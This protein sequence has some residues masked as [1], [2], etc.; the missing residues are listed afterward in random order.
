MAHSRAVRLLWGLQIG[1]CS[2]K[3]FLVTPQRHQ[4]L[5]W[6]GFYPAKEK[7]FFYFIQPPIVRRSIQWMVVWSTTNLKSVSLTR[8]HTIKLSVCLPFSSFFSNSDVQPSPWNDGRIGNVLFGKNVHV[9]PFSYISRRS[10]Q[11]SLRR[12]GCTMSL[13]LSK[14][15]YDV[16]AW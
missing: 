5:N 15:K 4:M 3:C 13:N 10:R 14:R 6:G 1:V 8:P 11:S 2:S 7:I 16:C 9:N 12:T